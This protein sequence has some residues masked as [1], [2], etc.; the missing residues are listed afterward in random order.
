MFD[1]WSGISLI[2]DRF[3]AKLCE[4]L[5]A[6]DEAQDNAA[7]LRRGNIRRVCMA[8]AAVQ[9]DS[10]ARTLAD[11]D[12][13]Q[14][15]QF[16]HDEKYHREIARLT[17]QER[18]KHMT[19][20]FAKYAGEVYAEPSEQEF[21]RLV[22][23]VLVIAISTANTLNLRLSDVLD[24][25][26]NSDSSTFENALVVATGRMAAAC[27]KL[28]HL[29]EFPYRSQISDGMLTVLKAALAV[30][31]ERSWSVPVIMKARLAPVKKKSIFH[32]K[33]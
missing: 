19:L 14:F 13:I 24:C 10:D 33:L 26:Q 18:L 3:G 28:D 12:K 16:E 2:P 1:N 9:N 30:C 20:H 5:K 6:E 21:Q 23:D 11:W 29:E 32:G 4:Y 31:A 15:E 7:L 25:D 22:T 8:L 27:E 17:V